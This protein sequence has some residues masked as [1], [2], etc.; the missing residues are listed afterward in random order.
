MMKSTTVSSAA[1][2][3]D[4]PCLILAGGLGTRLRPV[5]DDLPK[6]MAAV[7][8]K[9]FLEYLIRWLRQAGMQR[10]I[11]C[12]GYKS[13]KIQHYFKS[14]EA[15][16]V[17]IAY[18]VERE[19]KGTWGAIRQACQ[20]VTDRNFLV[21]NGDSWL[22]IDLGR[23]VDCHVRRGGVATIAAVEVTDASRFGILD[24]DSS[25][26]ITAFQEKRGPGNALVNGGIYVFS[27]DAFSIV[28]AAASSLEKEAFPMLL[29][30]GVFAMPVQGYFVDIGLPEEYKKLE[31]TANTW[32]ARLRLQDGGAKAC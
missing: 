4:M 28:P 9:P 20:F 7:A 21:L 16:D 32:V 30:H 13:E 19:P 14:G 24:V 31:A 29:P 23:L 15:L 27:R 22:Q 12:T 10:V 1:A 25:G 2:F 17:Q 5:L 3:L 6:P 26:R 8:G 18:S 11:L